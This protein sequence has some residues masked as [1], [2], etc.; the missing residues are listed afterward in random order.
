MDFLAGLTRKQ[1][2]RTLQIGLGIGMLIIVILVEVL[3]ISPAGIYSYT[4]NGYRAF[5]INSPKQRVLAE[6]NRVP[7]IRTLVTCDPYSRTALVTRRH[8]SYNE[9]LDTADIWIARYRKHN[10]L[11]FLFQDKT[12]VRML[13]LK[14]RFDR[15]ISSPL[16]DT[17]RTDLLQ[18]VD[19]F[20]K[21]QTGHPVFYH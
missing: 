15:P 16:F 13:L 18:D 19:R 14:T 8:F 4:Q 21:N 9:E 12:L 11:I 1:R 5:K 7:A 2:Q 10:V 6:I 17:C 3:A 20:L